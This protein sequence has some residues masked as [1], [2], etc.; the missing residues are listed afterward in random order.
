MK[1]RAC[2]IGCKRTP[3]HSGFQHKEYIVSDTACLQQVGFLL[4][5][6]NTVTKRSNLGKK[7]FN[8]FTLPHRSSSSKEIKAGTQV[9][10]E[11]GG[12]NWCRS[13]GGVLLPVMLPMVY[14]AC[15]ILAPMTTNPV[16]ALPRE[17]SVS[18]CIINQKND[19]CPHANLGEGHSLSLGSLF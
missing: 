7:G 11:P 12:R 1:D 16:V 13:R 14:P 5:G 3:C 9:R 19:R 6:W 2:L 10:Q 18:T 4:L 15:F 8:S 17:R